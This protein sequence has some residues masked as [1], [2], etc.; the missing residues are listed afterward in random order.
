MAFFCK[1]ALNVK[2]ICSRKRMYLK[3]VNNVVIFTKN[4]YMRLDF[5][6]F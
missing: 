4:N 5:Y 2:N 3:V 1:V 6:P